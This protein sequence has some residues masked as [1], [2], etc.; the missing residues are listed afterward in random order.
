MVLKDYIADQI[1]FLKTKTVGQK[2][3]KTM[4]TTLNEESS[5]EDIP[6][7]RVTEVEF[8]KQKKALGTTGAAAASG[9]SAIAIN[10]VGFVRSL[11]NVSPDQKNFIKRQFRHQK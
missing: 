1:P 9:A 8:A 11:I 2:L 7:R 4:Q 10:L 6:G 3:V 5:D